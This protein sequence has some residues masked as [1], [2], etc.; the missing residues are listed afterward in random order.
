MIQVITDIA[1][2]HARIDHKI[3]RLVPF[4]NNYIMLVNQI[5]SAS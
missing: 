2:R 3:P 4:C 5:W 1:F